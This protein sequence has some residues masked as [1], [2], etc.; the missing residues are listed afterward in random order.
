MRISIGNWKHP[1][2]K[3]MEQLIN[4]TLC[5]TVSEL[6]KTAEASTAPNL[7]NPLTARPLYL[8]LSEPPGLDAISLS[9]LPSPIP[10]LKA[11]PDSSSPLCHYCPPERK[12]QPG[13]EAELYDTPVYSLGQIRNKSHNQG[14]SR[15]LKELKL[16][17]NLS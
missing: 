4:K 17:K 9:P 5:E 13:K 7:V 6:K 11:Q 16:L 2:E 3:V 1:R 12:Q 14:F 8:L 15:R 10:P